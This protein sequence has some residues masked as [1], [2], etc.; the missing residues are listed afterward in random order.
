MLYN[1]LCGGRGTPKQFNVMISGKK[2]SCCVVFSVWLALPLITTIQ[3]VPPLHSTAVFLLET[4]NMKGQLVP[5]MG[6][7]KHD[8]PTMSSREIA[9]LTG[10][11]H[12][13]VLR[14]IRDLIA[15]EILAAQ[16]E[17]LKFEYRGQQ[18][19]YYDLGKRDSLVLVARLSPEFT[20][21]IVDRWQELEQAQ[22]APS[23]S[24]SDTMQAAVILLESAKRQLNL[25]N[26]SML[27]GYQKLQSMAGLPNLMPTYA[28]DAPADAVDGS[29]RSTS[30]LRTILQRRDFPVKVQFAYQRLQ[31]LGIVQRMSRPSTKGEKQFWSITASGLMFGKN[32]TSPGNPRETQPHFFDTR[33]DELL[34]MIVGAK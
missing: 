18:F 14:T 24:M 26:S 31:E 2:P 7:G 9:A 25:S 8:T 17:P 16:I 3:G 4:Q 6:V 30:A 15:A 20:A 10:K 28:I 12:K 1:Y 13:N 11:E 32:M 22:M 34:A 19:D 29:S 21:A 33:A 5:S 23:A 27:G